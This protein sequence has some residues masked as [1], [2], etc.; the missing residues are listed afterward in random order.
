MMRKVLVTFFVFLGVTV[1]AT[2]RDSIVVNKSLV[3]I[4]NRFSLSGY[5]VVNYYNYQKYDTDPN[6]KNKFDAE[7][8]NL[9]LGYNFSE[10]LKFKSEIEFEHSGTG[11]TI[12]LDVHE[13]FG[14][15]E[16][17]IEAGGAVKLEQIFVEYNYKPYLNFR[18]GRMKLHFNLAQN[19]DRPISYFTTHR[20]EME[21]EVL[22]LGWYENGI[23]FYG[24]ITD[25]IKYE[26]SLTNGLDATGFSSRGWIKGGHQQRFEMLVGESLAITARIDYKFGKNKNTFA[27]IGFYR[28]DA[29]ANRPKNDLEASGNVTIVEGHVTYDEDYLRFNS[30]FLYGDLQNSDLISRKNASLSNNLGVKRTPVGKNMIG[31]SFEAGYEVLHLFNN[32]NKNKLYPF[33]RYEYYDTMYKTEG[34]VV[35]KPRWERS[36]ITTGINW[37]VHPQVVVKAQYQNRRLGSDHYDPVTTLNTGQKQ[38]EN[39]FSM[40]IGFSF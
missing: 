1:C 38:Q 27:G 22:P 24:N 19:L 33:V 11:S 17:E 25:R 18:L 6:I 14:E 34:V 3:D 37:F 12:E 28:N 8:L 40:G 21:N 26:F 16:Q 4:L 15:Y 30:V 20:Q 9:Y 23:Q 31:F 13:E 36:A 5:G 10:N 7:R 32:Y 2:E 35:K 39:T 29:I